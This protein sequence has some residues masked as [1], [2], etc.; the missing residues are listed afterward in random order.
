VNPDTPNVLQAMMNL[1]QVKVRAK[2]SKQDC[3]G[4]EDG[5]G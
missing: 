4:D 3:S 2:F 1:K 5:K